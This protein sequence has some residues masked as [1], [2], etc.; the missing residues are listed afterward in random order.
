MYRHLQQPYLDLRHDSCR[1]F[2][3]GRL[4]RAAAP[5]ACPRLLLALS[6]RH[7]THNQPEHVSDT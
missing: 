3:S 1:K 7:Q 5:K 4:L 6:H 2:W